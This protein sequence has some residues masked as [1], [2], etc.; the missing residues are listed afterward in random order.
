[1]DFKG[2]NDRYGHAVG[3]R[4]LV[5][6]ANLLQE[7][8]GSSGSVARWGGEEFA[9]ALQ[10]ADLSAGA[11]FAERLREQVGKHDWSAFGPGFQVHLSAGVA[12]R[13]DDHM[14]SLRDL[15]KLADNR[16]YTAKQ[17]GR[18]RVVAAS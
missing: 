3:D 12:S 14:N 5:E 1:D 11:R 2:I 7:V 18:N 16:M 10:D 13:L 8:G 4:V 15:I 6:L 17:K 9:I